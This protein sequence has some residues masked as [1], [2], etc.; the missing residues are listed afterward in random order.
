[1]CQVVLLILLDFA[2][3]FLDFKVIILYYIDDG[4]NTQSC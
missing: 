1:M 3:L 4:D 2:L